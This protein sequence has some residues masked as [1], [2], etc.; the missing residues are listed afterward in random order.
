MLTESQLKQLRADAQENCD[1]RPLQMSELDPRALL[2]LI[3]E[4][5][6]ARLMNLTFEVR[7]PPPG[8][9]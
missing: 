7:D 5:E 8:V 4:V 6:H 9:S 3:D 1:H 2:L